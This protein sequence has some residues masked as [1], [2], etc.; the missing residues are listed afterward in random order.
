MATAH[1]VSTIASS[2]P[3]CPQQGVPTC[4]AGPICSVNLACPK[5]CVTLGKA[6]QIYGAVGVHQRTAGPLPGQCVGWR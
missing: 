5:V 2:A 3:Y 6:L 4:A 1:L